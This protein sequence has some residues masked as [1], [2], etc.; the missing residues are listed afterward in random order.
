MQDRCRHFYTR[1]S[2]KWENA[3]LKVVPTQNKPSAGIFKDATVL[4][5]RK[6]KDLKCKAFEGGV[7]NGKGLFVGGVQRSK[8][9]FQLNFACTR[10]Y[11]VEKPRY[12]DEKVVFGGVLFGHFGHVI[13]D[14][15]TR[16]W[17]FA[18]NHG[19]GLKRVFVQTPE[20][21]FKY[22]Q[23]FDLAGMNWEI[24]NEPTQY[25]EVIVPE[26]AYWSNDRGHPVW[27]EWW[28]FL[29]KK[30]LKTQNC[31]LKGRKKQDFDEI[32]T[33]KT[34]NSHLKCRKIYLT[35]TQFAG[36]D[37]INEAYYE[38][39]FKSIGFEVISPEKLPL[40]EQIAIISQAS[41]IV[42]TMGTLA[43]MLVFARDGADVTLLLRSPS[44]VL[45]AQLIINQLRRFN[46][47]CIDA[48]VNPLPVSQSNGAFLYA[49]TPF[50]REF[51]SDSGLPEPPECKITPEITF[52][53][54]KK[55]TENYKKLLCWH[56]IKD[57]PCIEFLS[58]LSYFLTG[59]E[60][61]KDTYI[62]YK[63]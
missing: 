2:I 31:T 5:L 26:E 37:G 59:E 15:S 56:Y 36:N 7:V 48:T 13:I 34:Q 12:I 28:D 25:R 10:G 9:N 55:W 35:R 4:P 44:S 39:Y 61:D 11:K 41:H 60:L 62:N 42:C 6:R 40:D 49:P 24:I 20:T 46:W 17:H 8:K 30:A 54:L 21:S 43:H 22:G 27:L 47:R 53:Y 50:F 52:T 18:E 32:S 57:F 16:L 51:C 58:S 45:P 63:P 23:F 38:N 3:L 29:Q 14:S 33:L 19:D 1:Y